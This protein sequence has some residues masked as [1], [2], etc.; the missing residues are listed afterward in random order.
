M[1]RDVLQFDVL[2]VGAGP[3]GL[4]AAIRIKQL[5]AQCGR[6]TRVCILEKAASFGAHQLSGAVVDTRALDELIPDWLERGAPAGSAVASERFWLLG[7]Q[8]AFSLPAVLMPP[9]MDNHA[10]RIMSLGKLCQWL[11]SEA[12]ALGVEL[13]AGFTASSPTYDEHGSLRGVITGDAGLDR[14]GK[15]KAG[16][17]PGV[18]IEAAYTLVAEGSRG[19]LTR[20]LET[21]F[22]LRR[23]AD[24]QQYALGLKELWQTTPASPHQAG[25]VWHTLGWPLGGDTGGGGFVYQQEDGQV[26]IGF[27]VH[28]NYRNPYL[29]PYEE[30][31]RFKTHP[32]IAGLL[33]G[34]KRLAYGARAIAEGGIQALPELVFPG[35][36]LIGCA[37][38]FVNVPRIKGIHNA[39]KSGMLA[40]EAAHAALGQGRSSD[41]LADYPASLR[42]SWVWQDLDAVRNTKPMLARWGAL[43]GT[44]AS[45]VELWLAHLG[46][47]LP[48]TLHHRGADHQS[49]LPASA[50][51]PI[52]YPRPDGKL[53]FALNDSLML[54]N[55][56]HDEDQPCHLVLADPGRAVS[57][58]LA[59]YAAPETRYCPAGVYEIVEEP[60]GPRLQINAANCLHCKTCDIKD[61]GQNITWRPPEGGSGPNYSGM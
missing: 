49:L 42:A 25:T 40:A 10:C 2:I 8:R 51:Q 21:R 13:F 34:G 26:A 11:A 43:A 18:L 29:N 37:A 47:R 16:H 31:Q 4:A 61:P 41:L 33:A 6:D 27:V 56:A 46:V 12:E 55:L 1:E 9:Q 17:A 5:D 3:A 15:P 23:S 57:D 38:G 50:C 32:L 60:Q 52:D 28:L 36:A 58:N 7:R 24:P 22:D 45:G 59:R 54:A 53:S 48:W 35:G 19:S 39:M 44:L 30:F 14:H 20:E